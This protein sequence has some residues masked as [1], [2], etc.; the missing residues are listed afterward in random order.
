MSS[1]ESTT[2]ATDPQDEGLAQEQRTDTFMEYAQGWWLRVRTGDIGSLPIIIGL[3]LIVVIFGSL[4][5]TFLTER[6]FTNL[7]LQTTPIAILAIGVVW[8]LLIAE[9]DLSVAYVSAVGGVIMALLLRPGDPGMPWPIAIGVA[10][11]VTTMIGFLY[12]QILTK[13]GVPSFVITLAGN[14][15]FFGV[16]LILTTQW[17]TAGT[18]VIQD[19][20]VVGLANNFLADWLGWLLGAVVVGGYAASELLKYRSRQERGLTTKPLSVSA[21]QI[22]GVA[23]ITFGAIF[24]ANLDRGVPMAFVIL[25]VFLAFWTFVAAKTP[26]G[27]HVYA[28]GGNPEAARRAGIDVARLRI[29]IFMINGF[30]AGVGGIMLASRLRSVATN[31]GGGAL[32]LNVIAAAVI[33]GTSLFG[34]QGRIV[35]ALYGALVIMAI[36]NGMDLL[37]LNTGTKFVITGLV[38]LAAVTIDSLSKRGRASSGVA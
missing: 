30:M 3:I 31:S 37:G 34:G 25:G 24:Y 16:V 11:L 12:G 9:I 14:L 2:E 23:L 29:Y 5:D 19:S 1:P 22:G 38:L 32:L 27:R 36:Q 10:L 15:A 33:G 18:T 35:S 20:F 6:N 4:R 28:V 17:S 26:F 13:L 21:F 7:L 8:I